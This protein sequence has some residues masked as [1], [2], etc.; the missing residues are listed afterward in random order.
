LACTS[1][2]ISIDST[3]LS[4]KNIPHVEQTECRGGERAPNLEARNSASCGTEWE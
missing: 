4:Q 3:E 2:C 1:N